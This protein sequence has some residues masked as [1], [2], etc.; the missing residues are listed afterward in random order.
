VGSIS[1]R[2]VLGAVS[3]GRQDLKVADALEPPFPIIDENAPSG[4]FTALLVSSRAIIVTRR[5]VPV[6]IIT[7]ADL[8]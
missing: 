8:L 2:A 7:R 3:E 5:G 6:G 4:S 1:D